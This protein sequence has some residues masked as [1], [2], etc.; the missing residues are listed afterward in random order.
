MEKEVIKKVEVP[1]EVPTHYEKAWERLIA[2]SI[3]KFADEK[4]CFS[5]LNSME[6]SVEMNEAAED[7]LSQQ[8]A[9]DKFELTLRRY[10]VPLSKSSNP[11]LVLRLNAL[12]TDDKTIAI[13]FFTVALRETLI[14]Y[15]NHK[16]YKRFITL[17]EE[18]SYGRVG[19]KFSQRS[20]P[21]VY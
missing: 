17:W 21:W 13:F 12:W 16:P 8:R 2:E 4:M 6:V 7:I 20:I 14:F 1:A 18:G 5:G 3:A 15:R 19:K 10:G 9:E 11:Y